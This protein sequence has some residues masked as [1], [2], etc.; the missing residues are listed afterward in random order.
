MQ[1]DL[2]DGQIF[3][4]SELNGY[5]KQCFD[6]NPVFRSVCVVGEI[7]NYKLYPSGHHYFSLKDA[8]SSLS[9]VMFKGSAVSLR[10][11]PSNGMNVIAMGSVSAYPRDGKYQL[12]CSRIMPAGAGELQLAFERLKASLSA[13]GLFDEENKKPIP[14]FPKRIA[15]ITSPAGAAVRDI[16]RILGQRWPMAEVVVVP[17]R[18]QGAEAAGE[19][20]GAISYVNN[21][22]PVDL[23]ITGRGGGSAEDLWCFNEEIV[24]RAIFAS[25]IPVISAVGHE[26]DVTISDYVADRRASTPSN[27]AEL[28]VP[29][30]EDI[31]SEIVQISGR[32]RALAEIL[33]SSKKAKL[34][35]FSS[36][37][38]L[39]DPHEIF[40]YR[41]MMLDSARDSI[42]GSVERILAARKR[43]LVS[44]VASVEALSPLKVLSRGY[45]YVT[46][47]NGETL[48]SA[49]SLVVGGKI[50]LNFSDGRANCRVESKELNNGGKKENQL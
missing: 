50:I 43:E 5:I 37:R 8:D 36:N 6:A 30:Q 18:V 11:R 42:S 47:E 14:A 4:V 27:A 22:L 39:A 31:R 35:V 24:A 17:V 3:S 25:M 34:S 16:I 12:Y 20:A 46:G 41:R 13:E 32:I 29:S 40:N 45:S 21:M 10:F 33:I 26:P 44:A 19:I 49:G 9:C 48:K 1:N 23:I 15:V 38:L 2:M 7:S 28:A